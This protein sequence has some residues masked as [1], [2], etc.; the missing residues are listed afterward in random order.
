M[1]LFLVLVFCMLFACAAPGY[2][3]TYCV[4]TSG[5]NGNSGVSPNCWLTIQHAA[6]TA[7]SGD[8]VNIGAGTFY[9]RPTFP[10]S[11]A[12][13]GSRIIFNGTRGGG[14]SWDT[15]IDGTTAVSATWVTAPEAGAGSYKTTTL[16]NPWMMTSN[17]KGIWRI[18]VRPMDGEN[19]G[20]GTGFQAMAHPPNDVVE[21]GI[22]FGDFG[23]GVPALTPYWYGIGALYGTTSGGT[24]YIRFRDQEHPST[25]N[26]RSAPSGA[27]VNVSGRNFL[28]FSN[29]R[30]QG[31][32]FAARVT[33]GSS[34]VTFDQCYITHGQ[35][36]FVDEATNTQLTNSTITYDGIGMTF[37]LGDW[38]D[39]T[40]ER[41]AHRHQYNINKFLIGDT[42]TDDGRILLSGSSSGFIISG[43]T[44]HSSMQGIVFGGATSGSDIF[45]NTIRNF[46]DNG[47]YYNHTSVTTTNIH[48]N[49]IYDCDHLMRFE[50]TENLLDVNIYANKLYQVWYA[51][52]FRPKHFFVS[53][54]GSYPGS[55]DLQIYH[56]T[57]AGAGR[58]IDGG[59]NFFW[60]HVRNNMMAV[61]SGNLSGGGSFGTF[62]GNLEPDPDP[63]AYNPMPNFVL[64]PGNPGLNSAPS[65]IGT[66]LPGMTSGYYVDGQPDVG[67]IQ[68][69]EVGGDT[70][71]PVVS[72][73][74]PAN[75]AT[76]SG[77]AVSITATATDDSGTVSGVQFRVD[78]NDIVPEDTSSPFGITWNSASVS[79][80]SH[81]LT[82]V[83][84]DPSGNMTTSS[85]ITV[86]VSNADT[87]PPVVSITAPANAA[88]VSGSAVSI[89]ATATDNSGTVSGV[90]FKHGTTNIGVED[91]SSPFAVSWDTTGL[92][93]GSYAL[94]AVARDPT[95]NTTTSSTITVTVS[96]GG[97][98][99][100]PVV[101]IVLPLEGATVSGTIVTVSAT[102]SDNV[103]V[104]GVQF[105]LDGVNLGSEQCCASNDIVW[106]TTT[107]SDGAHVLTALARDAA[108]NT[109]L[110]TAV[111]VTVNNGGDVIVFVGEVTGLGISANATVSFLGEVTGL[112]VSANATV[113]FLS[114]VTGLGVS[115]NS[116]VPFLG[117]VL[118]L[119]V[120]QP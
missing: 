99:T 78:G 66:G 65:L 49:L 44:I 23:S 108:N 38:S 92:A 19:R 18:N 5:N 76:V 27:T 24:T 12:N 58:P 98:T 67:A 91:T 117:E 37:P 105:K 74:A 120:T 52:G 11:G 45:N 63:W 55:S 84:R 103:G 106:N 118:G 43:N 102:A 96:N 71:P 10:N 22:N 35:H 42:D 31:G 77:S 4:S 112:G 119:N 101:T 26:L 82:A 100:P 85:T 95:G 110:S 14:G 20:G 61:D 53:S 88:T 54:R 107:T 70:T 59:D 75:A 29:L 36:G 33:G 111:N 104:A 93:N 6:N 79:N 97:D 57:F 47:F 32:Q 109:T 116:T 115:A 51:A 17:D 28:T 68:A 2:T 16:G 56:N 41:I 50:A 9:E 80:G 13:A 48:H 46:S 25:M 113:P 89:T 69:G 73:T 87:T 7:V 94:T 1:P 90:Q 86:T 114:E 64:P 72:I 40:P 3:A 60:V 39:A 81:A 62:S 83:A 34:N 30:I 21:T 15:I 8:T